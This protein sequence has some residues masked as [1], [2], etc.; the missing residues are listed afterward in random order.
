MPKEIIKLKSLSILSDFHSSQLWACL[1][2]FAFCTSFQRTVWRNPFLLG[3]LS[4]LLVKITA[5][6]KRRHFSSVRNEAWFP[7]QLTTSTKAGH[8]LC[9]ASLDEKGKVLNKTFWVLRKTLAHYK[10]TD[11]QTV[12]DWEGGEK[13]HKQK[14]RWMRD[15]RAAKIAG[16]VEKHKASGNKGVKSSNALS[17]R[18]IRIFILKNPTLDYNWKLVSAEKWIY[19]V[20]IRLSVEGSCVVSEGRGRTMN[21]D[22]ETSKAKGGGRFLLGFLL[23]FRTENMHQSAKP[24]VSWW[25]DGGGRTW[26]RLKIP[27]N[28]DTH[29]GHSLTL[30]PPTCE[31]WTQSKTIHLCQ[32]KATGSSFLCLDCVATRK[33]G[34]LVLLCNTWHWF[35]KGNGERAD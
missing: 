18:R 20:I 25:R 3:E 17:S 9:S 28:N 13:D 4:I 6:Y 12:E 2:P 34:T 21:S 35:G 19:D 5:M 29:S 22:R 8:F 24:Q 26:Q 1:F 7:L 33:M 14:G 30:H 23:F 15:G 27:K 16:Q 10:E 32:K 31:D 11:K